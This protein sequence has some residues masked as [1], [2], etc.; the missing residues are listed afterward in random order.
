MNGLVYSIYGGGSTY[1]MLIGV[2]SCVNVLR[3]K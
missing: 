3:M 2:A 1:Y